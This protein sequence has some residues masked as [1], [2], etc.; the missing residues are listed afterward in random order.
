MANVF[1]RWTA[2]GIMFGSIFVLMIS[3]RADVSRLCR[4]PGFLPGP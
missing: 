4:R 1:L 2:F 3:D